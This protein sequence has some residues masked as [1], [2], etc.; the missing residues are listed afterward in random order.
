[1]LLYAKIFAFNSGLLYANDPPIIQELGE[2]VELF[3]EIYGYSGPS[4][5]IYWYFNGVPIHQNLIQVQQG[6]NMIQN[7]GASPIPNVRSVITLHNLTMSMFGTYS[8]HSQSHLK[9]IT[10]RQV[11]KTL[12]FI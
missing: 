5:V 1:M 2:S 6:S 11:G 10:L 7:K 3:C 4:A 8:C 9:H 12:S